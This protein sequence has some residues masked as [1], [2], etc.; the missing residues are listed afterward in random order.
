MVGVGMEILPQLSDRLTAIGHEGHLLV[1]LHALGLQQLEEPALRFLVDTAHKREAIARRRHVFG[2][3]AAEDETWSLVQ[4]LEMR[5][6]TVL[7]LST[8][9]S[10]IA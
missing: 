8:S 6:R 1:G 10:A 2:V 5:L 9:R 7:T 4:M 3:I